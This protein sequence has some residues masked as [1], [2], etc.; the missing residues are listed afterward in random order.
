MHHYQNFSILC[1]ECA[2]CFF[3]CSHLLY[4][5]LVQHMRS[6][7]CSF[8]LMSAPQALFFVR[9]DWL[10]VH[11]SVRLSVTVC[12]NGSK[13]CFCLAD[14][15]QSRHTYTLGWGNRCNISN[16]NLICY[17]RYKLIWSYISLV[18]VS[19]DVQWINIILRVYETN[20][21]L[22]SSAQ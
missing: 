3:P 12:I 15:F 22:M 17:F 21:L 20:S 9:S 7:K 11:P 1:L 10:S 16:A 13:L 8:S 5:F 6:V 19:I 14:P 2:Y 18:I 4:D